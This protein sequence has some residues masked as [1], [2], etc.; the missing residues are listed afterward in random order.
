M[1][2]I[3][4]GNEKTTRIE[5]RSVAPDVNPY[6][7][8]FTIIKTGLEDKIPEA[9]NSDK[10]SRLRFLPGTIQD[11]MRIFKSSEFI[12]KLMGESTK[13]KYLEYKQ[14]AAYRTPRE[15][16]ARIK[17]S[18]IVYHHEVTNQYLWNNF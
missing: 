11:S 17:Q 2:R 16:G 6:L 4:F 3:P 1:I 15:L 18:E 5:I 14:A 10:R 12:E 8:L 9:D 13:E 7:L